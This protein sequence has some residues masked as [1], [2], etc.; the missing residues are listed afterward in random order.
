MDEDIE[1]QD[2]DDRGEAL[3]N[4]DTLYYR[5]PS[6]VIYGCLRDYVFVLRDPRKRKH[7]E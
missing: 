7:G 5:D 2:S 3:G 4:Q 1:Y 6:G